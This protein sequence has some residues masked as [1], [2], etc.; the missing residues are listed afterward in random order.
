M[1]SRGTTPVPAVWAGAWSSAARCEAGEARALDNG[2]LI[3]LAYWQMRSARGS[4][5]I[6]SLSAWSGL[7]R[8]R[9]RWQACGGVLVSIEAVWIGGIMP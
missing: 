6:F 1:T 2:S 8:A 5:V 9:I 3:R 4:G 7:H